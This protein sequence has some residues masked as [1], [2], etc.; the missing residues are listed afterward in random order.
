M[1]I[2]KLWQIGL[3]RA[4]GRKDYQAVARN[5]A[6]VSFGRGLNFAWFSFTLFWFW[7]GWTQI[8]RIFAALSVAQWLGVSLATWLVATA[9]STSWEWPCAA[10]LSI[11]T[12]EGPVLINRYVRVIFA[13]GL[14]PIAFVIIGLLN[15]P[16]PS[17]VYKQF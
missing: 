1:S 8:G 4:M 17:I 7:G 9:T 6:Y 15:Q 12:P 3:T 13:T 11:R 2:N 5:V 14:G 10:L 16:A